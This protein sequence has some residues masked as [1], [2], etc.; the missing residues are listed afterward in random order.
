MNP[1]TL[2]DKEYVIQKLLACGKESL[3]KIIA[4]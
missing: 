3:K 2:D 4:L 1:I